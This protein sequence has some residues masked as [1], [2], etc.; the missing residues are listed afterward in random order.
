MK[1]KSSSL[2]ATFASKAAELYSAELHR[3][4][5]RRM[6]R[7]QEIEDLVQE[8]YIRLLK[9]DNGEFV[10]NPRAYILQT[11]SHVFHDYFEKDRR[12]Q[13]YVVTDSDVVERVSE[14]PPELPTCELAQ[15]LSTQKQLNTALAQLS[16]VHASVLLMY[17]REGYSYEEIA[18]QL[19]V[20]LR[21]VKRYIANAKKELMAID[22]KWE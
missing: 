22:W 14:N 5:A 7:P 15:R 10:R 3:F 17:Y 19:K 16:P 6:H 9:I 13:Q 11:A 12:T 8:V 2:L 4:L 18:S 1:A 20:S 21:Q